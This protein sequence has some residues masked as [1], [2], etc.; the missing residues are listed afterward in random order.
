MALIYDKALYDLHYSVPAWQSG[1]RFPGNAPPIPRHHYNWFVQSQLPFARLKNNVNAL[2]NGPG[3]AS[4]TDVAI[5]GGGYG[6]TAE[7]LKD[8]KPNLS[9][10]NIEVS[11]HVINTLATSEETD[12]RQYL[13]DDG[14][15][16]DNLQDQITFMSPVDPNLE[17]VPG[18]IWNYWLRPDGLRSSITTLDNDLSSNGQRRAVRTAL[19]GN[20]DALITE[21]SL[22]AHETEAE[23]DNFL[24]LVEQTRPN[25]ACQVVHLIE[26]TPSDLGY[27][28]KTKEDWGTYL[29]A[30]GFGN[31]YIVSVSD[32]SY[33]RAD[34]AGI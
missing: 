14:F 8:A 30:R 31:H 2:V 22:D 23:I 6:W 28:S 21:I 4:F 11:P 9:V 3:W 18:E 17:L 1:I 10:I 27:I 29:T 32:G 12:I 26:Y 34:G 13:I 19:G 7:L 16:P 25:P 24:D 15:D 5:I 33:Q 20:V